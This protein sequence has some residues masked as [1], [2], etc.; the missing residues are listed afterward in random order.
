MKNQTREQLIKSRW[1]WRQATSIFVI[2][3][4]N[5]ITK[6][7]PLTSSGWTFG[8]KTIVMEYPFWKDGVEWSAYQY[9][10]ARRSKLM[11]N[12]PAWPKLNAEQMKFVRLLFGK[13]NV[14]WVSCS[15][16]KEGYSDAMHWNLALSN[17][18]L[19]AAFVEWI[20]DQKKY[21]GITGAK[22]RTGQTSKSPSWLWPEM[23]DS[24][25]NGIRDDNFDSGTHSR[26][27]E[28]SN[29]LCELFTK[30]LSQRKDLAK[31]W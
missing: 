10:L 9:E 19:R 20:T 21:H 24:S 31:R 18:A 1:W 23:L 29:Q 2:S 26:A 6:S 17:G 15:K 12:H 4:K 5:H 3:E 30:E 22:G 14:L 8:G 13:S 11:A 7:L 16:P 25:A 28:L 27:K